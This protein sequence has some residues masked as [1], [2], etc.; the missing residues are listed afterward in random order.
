MSRLA[1]KTIMITGASAGI[2]ECCARLFAAEKSN[3]ILTARRLERLES[4]KRD[5]TQAHPDIGVHVAE[6]DVTKRQ[7]VFD[8]VRQLPQ[9]FS[10]IDVLVNNAGLVV[11]MEHVADAKPEDIDIIIDTNVKGL[12]N[13]TQAVLPGMKKRNSGHII[14][15]SSIAGK[16]AY[17]GGSI[18]CASK[19]AVEAITK[20]LS[21]ELLATPLRVT[22]IAPG[23]VQTEFSTIRFRGDQQAADNVYKGIKPL[24]GQDVAELVVFAASRPEHV[25]I[26]DMTVF[27]TNQSSAYH[28][29]R[30]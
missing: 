24:T 13:V 7:A 3:L 21:Q 18:Y 15:L 9:Q 19:H 6:L 12:L 11:G 2:G 27:P 25:Q 17:A 22:S 16:Q 26:A 29:H 5:L 1:G 10:N 20:A 30:G 28:V 4:L 8:A 23:L 14:N